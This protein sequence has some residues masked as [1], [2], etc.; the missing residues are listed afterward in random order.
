M[1]IR[2]WRPEDS[3]STPLLHIFSRPRGDRLNEHKDFKSKSKLTLSCI[4]SFDTELLIWV[5]PAVVPFSLRQLLFFEGI[6]GDRL[7]IHMVHKAGQLDS[8]TLN[9]SICLNSGRQGR[10]EVNVVSGGERVQ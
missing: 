2:N 5:R 9:K 8:I 4:N 7:N 3:P 1:R 10:W 6:C